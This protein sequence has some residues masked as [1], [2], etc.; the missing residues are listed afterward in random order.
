M[1]APSSFKILNT[2]LNYTI[3]DGLEGYTERYCLKW[4][5]INPCYQI[6]NQTPLD[7]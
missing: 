7:E 1:A 6:K 5:L 4:Y 3:K 2:I